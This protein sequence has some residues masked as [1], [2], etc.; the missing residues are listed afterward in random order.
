MKKKHLP[1]DLK[2]KYLDLKGKRDF[3][4]NHGDTIVSFYYQ[5]Q[6]VD[7]YN[8]LP[9]KYQREDDISDHNRISRILVDD[10]FDDKDEILFDFL[11]C[12]VAIGLG[13]NSSLQDSPT[14]DYVLKACCVHIDIIQF[15]Y[16]LECPKNEIEQYI[17]NLL[18]A[19]QHKYGR[20]S[21]EYLKLCLHLLSEGVAVSEDFEY[22]QSL[23]NE[24]IDHFIAHLGQYDFTYEVVLVFANAYLEIPDFDSVNKLINISE[25]SSQQF[26]NLKTRET[27]RLKY[28]LL[29]ARMLH[30]QGLYLQS[31]EY[32]FYMLESINSE[33]P[34]FSEVC[35]IMVANCSYSGQDF[36]GWVEKGLD[37]CKYHNDT[38]SA[39]YYRLLAGLG[40]S[41][42]FKGNTPNAIRYGKEVIDGME[43]LYG[44][45]S[46]DYIIAVLDYVRYLD[47]DKLKQSFLDDIIDSIHKID[48]P[49]IKASFYNILATLGYNE[50]G[51]P[52]SKTYESEMERIA[53]IALKES[54]TTTNDNL[55]ITARI[56]LLNQLVR[57]VD[58]YEG[59]KV[60][61]EE[62]FNFLEENKAKMNDDLLYGFIKCY[63]I[64][65]CNRNECLRALEFAESIKNNIIRNIEMPLMLF[66]FDITYTDVLLANGMTNEAIAFLKSRVN[67]IEQKLYNAN[68]LT[69]VA[70]FLLRA[71][72]VISQYE[73]NEDTYNDLSYRCALMLKYINIKFHPDFERSNTNFDVSRQ[74]SALEIRQTNIESYKKDGEAPE[75]IKKLRHKL[76]YSSSKDFRLPQLSDIQLPEASVLL[77]IC[78]FGEYKHGDFASFQDV[79]ETILDSKLAIFAIYN[80]NNNGQLQTVRLSDVDW[81]KIQELY[82][83]IDEI[84]IDTFLRG[85]YDLFFGQF[86]KY[87]V[88]RDT[89][90]L[91]L[92]SVLPMLPF[93]VLLD[94]KNIPLFEK[95]NLINVL[96]AVDIRPDFNVDLKDAL[97]IGNPCYNIDK[98]HDGNEDS[99]PYTEIEVNM[100]EKL[101][102]SSKKFLQKEANKSAFYENLDSNIIH[103]SSHGKL[104]DFNPEWLSTPLI[105]S[106]ILLSGWIDFVYSDKKGGYGNGLLTAEDVIKLELDET[107]LVVFSTCA[108]GSGYFD[109]STSVPKGLR[110]A[111]GFTGT[112]ASISSTE[113]VD[114]AGT[115]LLMIL[116]Y[117]NLAHMPV[118]KALNEAKKQLRN[119]S[120]KDIKSNKILYLAIKDEA[121]KQ[122]Q[123][124]SDEEIKLMEL[125]YHYFGHM[126]PER[127]W[128]KAKKR[129]RKDTK[130]H[131]RSEEKE[132]KMK[133]FEQDITSGKFNL[134]Y[135]LASEFKY[136]DS[137]EKLFSDLNNWNSF[138]CYFYGGI[139]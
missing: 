8:S 28:A 76:D 113:E 39:A 60:E 98:K 58:K 123:K 7:F 30:L 21:N 121:K 16:W 117:H 102:T 130:S 46:N 104:D 53:R 15:L 120:V 136:W 55:K 112:K 31:E 96:T 87:F 126:S 61:I 44:K 131:S 18:F 88:G 78:L 116:F 82:D 108:S 45:E 128:S 81:K 49:P 59:H 34:L 68:D 72:S 115:A 92:D 24:H 13:Y 52:I 48:F 103:I 100:I 38:N 77:D 10:I 80:D 57:Q 101:M 122:M 135:A 56:N 35:S 75:I 64:Y 32:C 137:E 11:Y 84:G 114:D 22:S 40:G 67:E 62:L 2:E 97:L 111:L 36:L 25:K 89:L 66:Q 125:F 23:F 65:Y 63:I 110:W 71:I 86:E 51:K 99:L 50:Y 90:Y 109:D 83:S 69:I 124:L 42:F 17:N 105:G 26:V 93:D 33:H 134:I 19:Y 133:Q 118:A 1:N 14:D 91:S 12:N 9:N 107:S 6:I 37:S 70:I 27:F 129:F 106:S 139:L 127:A 79:E 41:E 74:M 5:V 132:Q 43:K 47:N 138:D 20:T 73:K 94:Y 3:A 119:L 95:Y 85:L 54:D 29:R 4:L